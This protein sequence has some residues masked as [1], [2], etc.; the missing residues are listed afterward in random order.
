MVRC[1]LDAQ[2]PHVHS[3]GAIAVQ[4][5]CHAIR[6]WGVLIKGYASDWVDSG[7]G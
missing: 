5:Q 2:P 7:Y 6:L 1:P 3:V 4:V